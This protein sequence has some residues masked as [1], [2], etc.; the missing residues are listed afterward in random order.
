MVAG[1]RFLSVTLQVGKLRPRK[2][3][4]LPGHTELET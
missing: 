4:F 2:V 1:T 3:E